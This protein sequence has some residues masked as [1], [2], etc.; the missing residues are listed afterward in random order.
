MNAKKIPT[1]VTWM[2]LGPFIA[3]QYRVPGMEARLFTWLRDFY[4]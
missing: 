2:L 3:K 1:I 4:A